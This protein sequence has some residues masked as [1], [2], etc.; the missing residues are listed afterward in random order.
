MDWRP[1][2]NG[3][4]TG[5]PNYSIFPLNFTSLPW[6]L[7]TY[8]WTNQQVPSPL[9]TPL[10][11]RHQASVSNYS[12]ISTE[13]DI[14]TRTLLNYTQIVCKLVALSQWTP[15][16]PGHM[17]ETGDITQIPSPRGAYGKWQGDKLALLPA[18]SFWTMMTNM[19]ERP[20]LY[21]GHQTSISY[22]ILTW[23]TVSI[24]QCNLPG[25]CVWSDGTCRY[26]TGKCYL[27]SR[28]HLKL[29]SRI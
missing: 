24:S 18:H 4:Q 10:Y 3:H 21:N 13:F 12:V 16:Y 29:I 9:W 23:K 19:W 17:S 15:P 26:W 28:F 2:C 22:F 7:V 27:S 25:F 6:H 11:N 5:I 1:L 20:P 8:L 14:H